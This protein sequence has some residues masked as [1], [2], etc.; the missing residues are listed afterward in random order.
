MSSTLR[1]FSSSPIDMAVIFDMDGLLIDSE[2][3]WWQAGVEVLRT[4]GVELDDSRSHETLGL[5]GDAA[6][7]HWFRY[8]P[9]TGKTIGQIQQEMN[10]RFMQLIAEHAEPLP[11]VHEVVRLISERGI[12]MRPT[13]LRTSHYA[14]S[15]IGS[16]SRVSASSIGS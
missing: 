4:V 14:S 16:S 12:P 5:R 15:R 10:M 9:W 13:R 1:V 11:G 8:F 7:A 3:L 2:P 6:L